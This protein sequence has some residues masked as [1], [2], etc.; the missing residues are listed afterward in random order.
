MVIAWEAILLTHWKNGQFHGLMTCI[1]KDGMKVV[2]QFY[3]GRAQDSQVIYRPDKT[4]LTVLYEDNK[5]K[6][7]VDSKEVGED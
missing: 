1:F 3:E 5:E 7:V 2:S 6:K 4:T